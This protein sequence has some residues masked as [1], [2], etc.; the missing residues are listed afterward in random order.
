[1]NYIQ[2]H[3]NIL[4][5]QKSQISLKSQ[6]SS[7]AIKYERN[8][9]RGSVLSVQSIKNMAKREEIEGKPNGM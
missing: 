5:V 2:N 3:T 9:E 1:M 7:K 8:S 6:S 4:T